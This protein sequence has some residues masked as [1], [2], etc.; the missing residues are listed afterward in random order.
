[1]DGVMWQ[2]SCAY[3][4]HDD[5]PATSRYDWFSFAGPAWFFTLQNVATYLQSDLASG[6]S[7]MKQVMSGFCSVSPP[8]N[9][10]CA[11]LAIHFLL[12]EKVSEWH[13]QLN[14]RNSP[15]SE[16]ACLLDSF[17]HFVHE[18][19]KRG[20]AVSRGFGVK[21]GTAQPYLLERFC[22]RWFFILPLPSS[23][24]CVSF[25]WS[26]SSQMNTVVEF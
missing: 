19:R 10:F 7:A 3:N 16:I 13:E 12:E 4:K 18:V 2:P 26:F 6:T 15:I 20:F 22:L 25:P 11:E 5:F 21:G 14:C 17:E 9:G 23:P 1:M 24:P 8:F